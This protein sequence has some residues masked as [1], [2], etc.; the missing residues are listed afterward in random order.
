M[1]DS[2]SGLSSAQDTLKSSKKHAF[3]IF[4][5]ECLTNTLHEEDTLLFLDV[6]KAFKAWFKLYFISSCPSEIDMRRRSYL[7]RD[8]M[9]YDYINQ[10]FI[11]YKLESSENAYRDCSRKEMEDIEEKVT[12]RCRE[13]AKEFD[14][15]SYSLYC[16]TCSPFNMIERT[17]CIQ[18][19]AELISFVHISD[20]AW[21]GFIRLL[22]RSYS[23]THPLS[24]KLFHERLKEWLESL[25]S[26]TNNLPRHPQIMRRISMH[27]VDLFWNRDP[28]Y[29][30]IPYIFMPNIPLY[31]Y[32]LAMAPFIWN[33][34]CSTKIR[35][36]WFDTFAIELPDSLVHTPD[37]KKDDLTNA[38]T[39]FSKSI[40]DSQTMFFSIG[41]T[42]W[43]QKSHYIKTYVSQQH[44]DLLQ[45]EFL[46]PYP[47]VI[48]LMEEAWEII[49]PT[50]PC[51]R[52]KKLYFL[53]QSR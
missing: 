52:C 30:L 35:I 2:T 39:M 41:L 27:Q 33:P 12:R 10:V 9:R 48:P 40:G 21:F 29:K 4:V 28:A 7:Q 47:L 13:C 5:E 19:M 6:Y 3:E 53:C 32:S 38:L 49:H 15:F 24:P 18:D 42:D 22:E 51:P 25:C 46:K 23:P 1:S 16:G 34:W 11:G 14:S 8:A 31:L 36:E 20:E 50:S 37:H 44:I 43:K 17:R 45:K 26:P